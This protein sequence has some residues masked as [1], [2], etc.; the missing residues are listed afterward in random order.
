MRNPNELTATEAIAAI[1]SGSITAQD[2]VQACLNRIEEREPVVGAWA[3]VA[4]E[5]ALAN[6]ASVD[7][8][9]E[10][11]ALAGIPFAA[12]DIIDSHDMPTGYG[13]PIY[14][15][16]RP[17]WDAACI[18]LT[19][20]AGGTLLGKTITTEFA[21]LTPGKT[22]NPHDPA[23]TP[24][25]SSSG[26]AAAVG[27]FMVPFSFGTQ[28]SQSTIRPAAY[29]GIHGYCPTQGDFRMSG[30]REASGSFDRLG[31]FARSIEDISLVRDVLLRRPVQPVGPASETPPRIGF[32]RTNL[33]DSF[34]PAMRNAMEDA[35]SRL[36][37]AGA[38]VRD[39]AFP[40][41][42]DRLA[43]AHRWVSSFEFARNFTHEYEQHHDLISPRLR[44]GRIADGMGCSFETYRDSRAYLANCRAILPEL[45]G[46]IDFLITP[47]A[48]G[49]AT[50][51]LDTT[52]PTQIGSIFTPLY[53]PC[54]S[55]P[56]FTGPNGL[57]MGLQLLS[58]PDTDEC[59]FR[60]ARWVENHLT[61]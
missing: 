59:L 42:F 39:F 1:G 48:F 23:R 17:I 19:R 18:A 11:T 44:D 22:A 56:V 24:G 53:L 50:T 31:L 8:A 38:R 52:G 46:D 10:Q 6:A 57:P 51:G 45:F 15:G 9:P 41:S 21:N 49:E 25:G 37:A 2:V 34:E 47:S 30:V 43:D 26:S 40:S 3:H 60:Q 35:A 32:C 28:T 7:A 29:C 54:L 55:L 14:D 58:L 20:A 61:A 16:H 36:S 5:P 4:G 12:K 33:W 27:D 13:S